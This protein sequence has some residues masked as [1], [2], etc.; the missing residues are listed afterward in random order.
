MLRVPSVDATVEMRVVADDRRDARSRFAT[1]ARRFAR[2]VGTVLVL[3]PPIGG[4]AR[5]ASRP[6]IVL[7]VVDDVR[8]DDIAHLPRLQ[9]MLF[10]SGIEFT[11]FV[12]PD[13]LC[14][15]SRMSILR[16]QYSHNTG[17]QNNQRVFA[18]AYELGLESSTVATWLQDAGYATGLFGKYLNSYGRENGP[19]R[20]EHVPPGWSE[21]YAGIPGSSFGF[22]LSHDGRIVRYPEDGPHANDVL[23]EL[24][25]G[26]VERHAEH[27]MFL[28]VAPGSAHGD[29][30]PAHRHE[31]AFADAEPPRRPS[32]DEDDVSDK[33]R[34][35]RRLSHL[36][37]PPPAKQL[38]R[39]RNRLRS[40]LSVE[41]LLASLMRS[42]EERGVLDDTYF[43][44]LSDNGY[45]YGEHRIR[46]SKATVYDESVVV[47]AAIRGP[48]VPRGDRIEHLVTN[49][50]LAVTI[51]ELAGVAPPEFVDGK[52]LLPL[53]RP[54]RPSPEVWR[55]AVP[56][57]RLEARTKGDGPSP[58]FLGL[59]HERWKYVSYPDTGEEELYDTVRDPFEL[60]S[61][62][63][64]AFRACRDVLR[65]WSRA[66]V[67][68]T[69]QE[70][71]DLEQHFPARPDRACSDRWSAI[72]PG[73]LP[74]SPAT[75]VTDADD[76][77]AR[78][79]ACALA[80]HDGRA[81]ASP[82]ATGPAATSNDQ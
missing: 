71:R 59:R 54:D 58:R 47:P 20:F 80:D 55:R 52:S 15:P 46:R 16:G 33:P 44:F 76:A 8:T 17:I 57:E 60:Q 10:R 37:V 67:R 74:W 53:L 11:R 35:I 3:L 36:P 29:A 6:N 14:G 73:L 18:H 42:L 2:L 7:L 64:E 32:F 13:A 5:A 25:V 43:I 65:A 9:E 48:G 61:L 68:C 72:A 81:T 69:G 77:T 75:L 45:H 23:A 38:E 39:Y 50:D 34:W 78:L 31:D 63:A 19:V 62:H 4:T 40:L 41:D 24:V 27:P 49:G 12:A 22:W 56:L 82:G 1:R 51:A 70:C 30:I 79:A 66:L 21:W 26:F 28:Y